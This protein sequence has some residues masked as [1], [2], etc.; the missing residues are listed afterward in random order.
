MRITETAIP[1]AY[2][3][4]LEPHADDRGA[5]F[6]LLRADLLEPHLGHSFVVG[7]INYSVSRR[8]TLRGIHSTAV[9]PGQE[10]FVTCLRGGIRDIIVDLRMG[11]PAFGRY[12]VTELVEDRGRALYIP[13]GVGHAFHVRADDTCV[14]YAVS[15]LFD[16]AAQL[17]VDPL[18]PQLALPWELPGPPVMSEKDRGARSL[19]EMADSGLLPKWE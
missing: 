11:S 15:T 3:I 9:P 12:V 18:D 8:N 13:D 1:G 19:A 2:V 17:E 7:Q 10:K 5:F 6:E 4:D 16:P 14:L